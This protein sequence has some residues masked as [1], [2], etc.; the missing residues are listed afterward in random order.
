MKD[1]ELEIQ[2]EE[3]EE[4]HIEQDMEF[5]ES[6]EEGAALG[7]AQKVKQLQEKIKLLEKEKQEY[8]DGW[9]RSR[10]DYANL[11]KTTDEDRKRMRGLV[12][13]N[14]IEDLLPAIDSFA[15][16]M[17]NKEAW[18]KVDANW[19]TG[20]E[21]IYQQIMNVLKDRNFTAFGAVGDTFDPALYEAVSETETDNANLEHKVAS[22]LQQGYKLGDIVLR[23]A[24]VS[25][26]KLK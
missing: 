20:V 15:M 18:E 12:E 23:A 17:A 6:D 3:L 7:G 24:R 8:L 26:Y 9:Q 21:Y 14:F 25:V 4:R 22:V 1:D 2:P 11:Q 19:R 13:E 16:A 10:A 5:V